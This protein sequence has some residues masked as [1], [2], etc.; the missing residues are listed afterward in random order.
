MTLTPFQQFTPTSEHISTATVPPSHCCRAVR[1][2]PVSL[3]V[4]A[5]AELHSA[6]FSAVFINIE[7]VA[8]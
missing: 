1:C 6:L 7:H 5:A 4:V 8:C 3:P 2:A